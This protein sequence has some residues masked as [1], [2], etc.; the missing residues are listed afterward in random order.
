MIR[1]SAFSIIPYTEKRVLSKREVVM[2]T[3]PL[4]YKKL[5]IPVGVEIRYEEF[6]AERL[7]H[8]LYFLEDFAKRSK[9][10]FQ[11]VPAITVNGNKA[12]VAQTKKSFEKFLE[13]ERNINGHISVYFLDEMRPLFEEYYA[14]LSQINESAEVKFT[15]NEEYPSYSLR[16]YFTLIGDTFFPKRTS[17]H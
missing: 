6:D 5:P 10:K 8:M 16:S 14:S 3:F 9:G 2:N 11:L 4:F 17:M 7:M 13:G 15:V 12:S 1:T